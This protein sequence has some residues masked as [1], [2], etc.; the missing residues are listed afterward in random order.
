ML[1]SGWRTFYIFF[2]SSRRRHTRCSRDW[3]SDVCSS[4]LGDHRHPR[5]CRPARESGHGC[6]RRCR[7]EA[8]RLGPEGARA[9]LADDCGGGATEPSPL[10]PPLPSSPHPL[11]PPSLLGRGNYRP[12]PLSPPP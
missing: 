10:S 5:E 12:S 1:V 7:G 4:D 6:L 9:A 2:F 11:F 3:S 8:A